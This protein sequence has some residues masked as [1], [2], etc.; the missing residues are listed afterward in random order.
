MGEAAVEVPPPRKG[1]WSPAKGLASWGSTAIR[2]A[3]IP[4]IAARVHLR[5][6]GFY[7]AADDA[8]RLFFCARCR[9]RT[10]VCRSCDRGQRYCSRSCSRASHQESNRRAARA[11][12]RS[13]L[14]ARNHARRQ[15]RYR[16]RKKKVTH[17]GSR[18]LPRRAACV[19]AA[20]LA[21]LLRA[22]RALLDVKR[23]ADGSPAASGSPR[24]HFCG[25][26]ASEFVRFDHLHT[27]APG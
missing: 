15:A 7:V 26:L 11:Y 8:P 5:L 1:A 18:P 10:L 25:R 9:R 17:Q 21:R 20:P 3:S 4:R 2:G 6:A 19:A 23:H 12:Q 14:G 24:C 13:P 16:A 22:V 27:E